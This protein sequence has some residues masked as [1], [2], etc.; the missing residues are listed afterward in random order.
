MN[1]DEL[2]KG[3]VT[4]L[5][6]PVILDRLQVERIVEIG[7]REGEFFK[8]LVQGRRLKMAVAVDVWD[9]YILDSQNDTNLP[10]HELA[11]MRRLFSIKFK[12]TLGL[13]V[14]NDFSQIAAKSFDD[15]IFDF[16]YIDADHSYPEVKRDLKM[17]YPKVRHDGVL[18]GHDY[19]SKEG[20]KRAVDEFTVRHN[21]LDQ[22]F[23]TH[24]SVQSFY[25]L[26]P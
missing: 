21:L 3:V 4:R 1:R 11:I 20:V 2:F 5:D 8:L 25:I 22:L 18:A 16:I 6:T 23:L 7:V 9:S 15:G 19:S 14:L 26:K 17:W 10:R 13:I 12:D 24:E